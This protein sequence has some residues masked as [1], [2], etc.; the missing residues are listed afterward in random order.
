MEEHFLYDP[1]N[2]ITNAIAELLRQTP[3]HLRP[4]NVEG[5]GVYLLYYTGEHHL[6]TEIHSPD[7]GTPLYAGS[8]QQL[9]QRLSI[10]MRTLNQA[11]D[12][13]RADFLCRFLILPPA[14]E[15]PIEQAAINRFKPWWNQLEFQ[16]FG[17]NSSRRVGGRASAWDTF[18]PGRG[19]A[20]RL[21]RPP[22]ATAALQATIAKEAQ[23]LTSV[24]ELFGV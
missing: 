5:G 20:L 18:H 16:G 19:G 23:K 4:V 7:A 10:H 12:L 22:D 9:R 13:D 3:F 17:N 14:W 11:W 24:T 1:E 6:Y 21:K 2:I 8:T 15:K